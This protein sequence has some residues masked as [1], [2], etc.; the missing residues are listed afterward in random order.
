[1]SQSRRAHARS[2]GFG[3]ASA[4]N[5]PVLGGSPASGGL[6][7]MPAAN[8]GM[9]TE[10]SFASLV[11]DLQSLAHDVTFVLD[12]ASEATANRMILGARSEFFEKMLHSEG[13]RESSEEKVRLSNVSELCLRGVI[14]FAYTGGLVSLFAELAGVPVVQSSAGV[15]PREDQPEATPLFGSPQ[16]PQFTFGQ[17]ASPSA[18][19]T[20]DASPR[21]PAAESQGQEAIVCLLC[22]L[23]SA[24]DLYQMPALKD[25][26]SSQLAQRVHSQN[27]ASV[28]QCADLHSAP[29][30]KEACLNLIGQQRHAV[31]ASGGLE[32]LSKELLIEA[33][34][35]IPLS[36]G[37]S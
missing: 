5:V 33:M 29:K 6:P 24:S 2:Q 10:E 30:L 7:T 27:A 36:G 1:M 3:F 21:S 15:R 31:H 14:E 22:E 11:A 4:Q 13:W 23:V 34:L 12:D 9:P 35:K 26:C 19:A 28:L 37:G 18:A 8:R 16:P 32:A 17:P 20:N 25:F